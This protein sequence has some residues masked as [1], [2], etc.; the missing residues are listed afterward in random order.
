VL[1]AAN[2]ALARRGLDTFLRRT[3]GT[4]LAALGLLGGLGWWHFLA[5]PLWGNV[6]EHDA[7]H[8]Y[9]GARYFPELGYT[10]LYL[11]TLGADLE[12]GLD[13]GTRV[14]DLETN[15]LAPAVL[16]FD[17]ARA[18]RERFRPERWHAFRSDLDW[19]RARLSKTEWHQIRRDHGFNG[20]PV[21]LLAGGLLASAPGGARALPWLALADPL[22]LVAMWLGV[23]AAFG[24]RTAAVAAVFW[25]TNGIAGFDWTGGVSCARTGSSLSSSA[26]PAC[27]ARGRVSRGC[28]SRRRP[29]SASFQRSSWQGSWRGTRWMRSA[30]ALGRRWGSSD[31]SPPLPPSPRSSSSPSPPGAPAPAPG[32]P[33]PRTARSSSRRPS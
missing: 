24:W 23:V 3:R 26:S 6:H 1:L 22:L 29:C 4:A 33:S 9:L 16:R 19:F 21:W 7:F 32:R 25:G 5:V 27:A 18:C 15:E 12:R 10:H 30:P 2:A 31:A 28:F 20:S 14:R 8:Y 13:P 17:D 11:C